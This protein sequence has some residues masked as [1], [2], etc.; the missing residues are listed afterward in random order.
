MTNIPTHDYFEH[1]NL[2]DYGQLNWLIHDL[3]R[4]IENGYFLQ[5]EA[6]SR[7][8][9][10]LKLSRKHKKILRGLLDFDDTDGPIFYIDEMP[11]P[12]Q[13]WHEIIRLVVPKLLIAKV[14]T[15]DGWFEAAYEGWPNLE[16]ALKQHGRHLSLPEG[17]SSAIDVVSV[18]IQHRLWLQYCFDALVGLGQDEELTL[19]DESQHYRIKWFVESLQEHRE[20]VTFLDLTLESMLAIVILPPKDREIFIK[21]MLE[22]LHLT[23]MQAPLADKLGAGEK[24]KQQRRKKK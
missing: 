8:E 15:S 2:D 7:Q 3:T 18:E 13:V 20:S 10:G 12:S 24:G 11:R 9:Q 16:K 22:K 23:S 21:L 14:V 5:W 1:R 19:E 4:H 6:V 17:I